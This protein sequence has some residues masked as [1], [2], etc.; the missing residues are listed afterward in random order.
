[1]N[2]TILCIENYQSSDGMNVSGYAKAY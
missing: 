1:L 2:E